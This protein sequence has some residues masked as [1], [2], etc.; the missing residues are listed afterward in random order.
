[1]SVTAISF[2]HSNFLIVTFY[3]SFDQ[4]T[5]YTQAINSA[6][7]NHAADAWVFLV[8]RDLYSQLFGPVKLRLQ[9]ERGEDCFY[10][11]SKLCF[12]QIFRRNE[13]PKDPAQSVRGGNAILYSLFYHMLTHLLYADE[14]PSAV[15]CYIAKRFQYCSHPRP[16]TIPSSRSSLTKASLFYQRPATEHD[17]FVGQPKNAPGENWEN[18]LSDR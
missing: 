10:E 9:D 15:I 16:G 4:R 14:R 13:A 11:R 8:T 12:R 3:Y 2:F 17:S 6:L 5:S 7:N 18:G 1:M